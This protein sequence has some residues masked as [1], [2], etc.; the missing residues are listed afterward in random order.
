MGQLISENGAE[1][2]KG[3]QCPLALETGLG[4]E[5]GRQ[6]DGEQLVGLIETKPDMD[7]G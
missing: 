1:M 5:T 7:I 2:H 6:P 3:G 4:I